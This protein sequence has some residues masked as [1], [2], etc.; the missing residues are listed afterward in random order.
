MHPP[1][2]DKTFPVHSAPQNKPLCRGE[3]LPKSEVCSPPDPLCWHLISTLPESHFLKRG[4]RAGWHP[5]LFLSDQSYTA[6]PSLPPL[7]LQMDSAWGQDRTDTTVTAG[8]MSAVCPFLL[9]QHKGI[10]VFW[11]YDLQGLEETTAR[12]CCVWISCVLPF[13]PPPLQLR[14]NRYPWVRLTARRRKMVGK[15]LA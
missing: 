7:Q 13:Q 1:G 3:L 10:Q 8:A 4:C 12:Y 15:S 6:K 14:Y 9:S 11:S 2:E 5:D